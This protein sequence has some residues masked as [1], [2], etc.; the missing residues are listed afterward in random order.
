M[1]DIASYA[2]RLSRSEWAWEF[3]RRNPE[4]RKA[5]AGWADPAKAAREPAAWGLCVALD[6]ALNAI[7]AIEAT[8]GGLGILWRRELLSANLTVINRNYAA[9]TIAALPESFELL[10]FDLDRP[11]EPQLKQ[12]RKAL[13]AL[14][15]GRDIPSRKATTKAHESRWIDYIHV[16][17]MI[18]ATG[19]RPALKVIAAKLWKD[20]EATGRAHA[21]KL[22]KDAKEKLVHDTIAQ[23]IQMR[24]RGYRLIIALDA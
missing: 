4:Y 14:R 20:A 2:H 12:A 10:A 9:G 24:D 1:V 13:S 18:A 19:K 11:V 6:P 17:D 7:E 16:L 15:K 21:A 8:E 23:A 3:L 22:W 5:W